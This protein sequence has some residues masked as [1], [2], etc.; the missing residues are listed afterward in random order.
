MY[1]YNQ[2]KKTRKFETYL[3]LPLDGIVTI[4]VGEWIAGTIHLCTINYKN[5]QPIQFVIL[6]DISQLSY[7]LLLF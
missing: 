4:R 7:D 3:S 5:K 6:F 1:L 2:S